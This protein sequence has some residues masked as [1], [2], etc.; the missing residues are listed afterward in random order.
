VA[1]GLGVGI[2][3]AVRGDD[4]SAIAATVLSVVSIGALMAAFGRVTR[5]NHELRATRQELATLAV[6]EERLRIARDL[7]DLLGHSLSVIALKSELAVRLL[8]RDPAR[9]AEE[10]EEIQTVT[11]EALAEVRDAVQGYRGLALAESLAGARS[12]LTAAG[13]DCELAGADVSLPADLDAVLA[14]AVRE[15]TTNVIRH[16]HARRCAIRIRSDRES[17]ALEIDDDGR[18]EPARD[19]GGSGLQGLRERAQR[20]RGTLEAGARPD[21][22]FRLRVTVPLPKP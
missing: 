20:V 3:G 16:S 19:H 21:G 1:A 2:L 18:A 9:A 11:R 15:G 5:V 7:H 10:L 17:A 22:G 8:E 6:A 4:D 12:A 13:I 14:W